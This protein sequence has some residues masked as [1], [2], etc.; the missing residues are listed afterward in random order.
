MPRSLTEILTDA[1]AEAL[2]DRFEAA[3]PDEF[4][5]VPISPKRALRQAAMRRVAAERAVLEAVSR[6]RADHI[7]W[8]VIGSTLGTSGESA[9][10]RYSP[11]LHLVSA[12]T[13]GHIDTIFENRSE[14]F[15][16]L[17]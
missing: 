13:Q 12:E 11:A 14:L 16:R 2:A 17:R 7:S 10:H 3:D 4:V 6:A 15:D 8:A 1:E 5:Q 9:R